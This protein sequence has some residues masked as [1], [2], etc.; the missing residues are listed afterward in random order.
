MQ[1]VKCVAVGDGAVGKTCL[2]VT[3][4]SNSFPGEYIPTVFDNYAVNL[5]ANG[6]PISL[7]LWD[8][9]GQDDY[10]RLR[11]L[12]YPNTDVF[13]ACYS[14]ISPPSYYNIKDKWV[15][16]IKHYCPEAPVILVGTKLDQRYDEDILAKL[17]NRKLVPITTQQG[18]ALCHQLKLHTFI[19]CSAKESTNVK[20]VFDTAV[21]A[22]LFPDV[23]C[24]SKKPKRKCEI[25]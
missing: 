25:L 18:D 19:E 13:L 6:K 12:S 22:V 1:N 16:E 14:V 23:P 7:Q 21:K 15:P 24:A 8:T 10:D 4:A 20:L 17:T 11:P 3:Y 5:M 9:A 2:L